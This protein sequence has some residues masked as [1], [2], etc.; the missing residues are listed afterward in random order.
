RSTGFF[1]PFGATAAV[2][3]ARGL[4]V[5]QTGTAL[6]LTSV[7]AAGTTQSWIDGGHEWQ[8]HVGHGAETGLRTVDMALQGTR[9]SFGALDGQA[10]L[11]HALLG[12][13]PRFDEIAAGFDMETVILESVIKRFPVSGIC[14]S[15]VLAAERLAPRIG[16]IGDIESVLVEMNAFEITYPGT[17]NS[18][19]DCHSFGERLMS[20]AFCASSVLANQGFR[21]D[22]FHGTENGA[23][24]RLA[25]RT[26]VVADA[27]LPLL[28]S[29]ITV[30]LADGRKL[31]QEV[32]NSRD[33]VQINSATVGDWARAL[34][35]EVGL[36]AADYDTLERWVDTL[37]HRPET[38]FASLLNRLDRPG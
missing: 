15:V 1:S 6:A 8:L 12:E 31:S 32:I 13:R 7:F 16:E 23:R 25:E 30:T 24:A 9:G 34:F 19:P 33:E 37:D 35:A 11:F 36:D 2:A 29:R 4:D 20:A 18:G 14:Q 5:T 22:D 3:V 27:D 10:G 26:T 38:D 21:F 17:M 28:S